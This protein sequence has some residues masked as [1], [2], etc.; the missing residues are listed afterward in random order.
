MLALLEQGEQVLSRLGSKA[1]L[2]VV[3]GA[4]DSD[5][6]IIVVVVFAGITFDVGP[7]SS[8]RKLR[9]QRRE[10]PS[11]GGDRLPGVQRY[12]GSQDPLPGELGGGEGQVNEAL[13]VDVWDEV[14]LD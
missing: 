3:D 13:H 11:D 2:G 8:Q 6:L 14:A 5:V 12:V 4:D 1:G 9:L 7:Q 10:A